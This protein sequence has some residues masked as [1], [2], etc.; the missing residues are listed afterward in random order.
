MP[1][2]GP[3]RSA[4]KSGVEP[5]R[6]A[7]GRRRVDGQELEVA[8]EAGRPG[9]DDLA[10]HPFADRVLVV[11]DLERAEAGRADVGGAERLGPSTVATDAGRRRAARP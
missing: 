7:A 10:A 4:W 3:R 8:P 6:E 1:R 11:G 9:L 5:T 2:A